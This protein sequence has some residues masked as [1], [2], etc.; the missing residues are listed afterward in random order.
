[1]ELCTL[2]V[3]DSVICN[4]VDSKTQFTSV[5]DSEKLESEKNNPISHH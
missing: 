2:R 5:N 3:T 4:S 1:M